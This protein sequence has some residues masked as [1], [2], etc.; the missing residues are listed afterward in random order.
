MIKPCLCVWATASPEIHHLV[1]WMQSR[2][3][4]TLSP[5]GM[6]NRPCPSHIDQDPEAHLGGP[7]VTGV[8]CSRPC[9]RGGQKAPGRATRDPSRACSLGGG[10]PWALPQL[11]N[12][13]GLELWP[14]QQLGGSVRLHAAATVP[15]QQASVPGWLRFRACEC[16]LQNQD[17]CRPCQQHER[18][19]L[20]GVPARTAALMPAQPCLVS[21]L[22]AYGP[23][24][25]HAFSELD[26]CKAG[27]RVSAGPL[28][29]VEGPKRE[30]RLLSTA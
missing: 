15:A 10:V 19:A 28:N 11:W 26:R 8:G 29:A 21:G 25:W 4:V 1:L 18:A 6:L 13:G 5:D 2:P 14:L 9:P 7:P 12:A 22:V 20:G 30:L 3:L 23:I 24:R 17:E 16:K 27:F